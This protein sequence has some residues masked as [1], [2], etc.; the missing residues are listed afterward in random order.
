MDAPSF[1]EADRLA[2][3]VLSVR[4][5]LKSGENVTIES[6]PTALPWALG[7]VREARR[8][9]AHPL[10]HYED[11]RSYWTAVDEGRFDAIGHASAAEWAAL[12]KT[13]VYIYFWGPEDLGRLQKLPSATFERLTA[14]NSKW[15]ELAGRAGV[16]GARMGIA[17]VTETNARRWGVSPDRWRAELVR[18]SMTDPKS[19]VRDAEK[20]RRAFERGNHVRIRHSNGTDI[21]LALAHRKAH[22]DLG[23]VTPASRRTPAGWM[24]SVPDGCVYVALDESTA[25][26]TVVANRDSGL[27]GERVQ[28]GRWRFRGG[29][30]VRQGYSLGAASVRAAY[31]R[32]G[33]GRELPAILEVGLDP[34]IRISPNL[35]EN[36]RGAV[37]TYVGGN[38][39]IGGTT[40]SSFMA[41]L[42][43][44]GAEL[45]VD[46][47]TVVRGGRIV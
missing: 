3:A 28:G 6:Y 10:L 9:G 1:S 24:A 26:G 36:E 25:E 38:L 22:V 44:G 14:F 33:K 35:G 45:S 16:R 15:Y 23:W 5:G 32:G 37:S 19:F 27:F 40:R 46:G 30:L 21:T 2:R 42:T 41:Y 17:R 39:R 29:R 43:V 11:E 13:D 4:L 12:E 20:V 34:S 31:S 8:M 7:F 47:R 18:A